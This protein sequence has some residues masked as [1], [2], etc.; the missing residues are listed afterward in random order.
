MRPHDEM[1]CKVGSK[2]SVMFT[3]QET[4]GQRLID[5]PKGDAVDQYA[6]RKLPMSK[7]LFHDRYNQVA[8][9]RRLVSAHLF[10]LLVFLGDDVTPFL[11]SA[12]Q[13]KKLLDPMP[14]S[15]TASPDFRLET[16]ALP[17]MECQKDVELGRYARH[18]T[19]QE[20][21]LCS[22]WFEM[23][24]IFNLTSFMWCRWGIT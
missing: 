24:F 6:G 19:E 10:L 8:E 5:L 11:W 14:E 18:S 3:S 15:L 23:C 9:T 16:G 22:N 12:E 7:L 20:I 1:V 2:T 13:R 4:T 17:V 21:H